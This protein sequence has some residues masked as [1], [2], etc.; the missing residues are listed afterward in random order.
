MPPSGSGNL[1]NDPGFVNYA[2][3]NFQLQSNSP[4]INSGGYSLGYLAAD[5]AGNPRVV[6]GFVDIGAYEYQSAHFILPWL[7]AQTYGL[8]LDGSI[9][10]D[11]DGMNNWQEAY[12]GTNPTNSA[13]LLKIISVTPSTAGA[14]VEWQSVPGHKYFVQHSTSLAAYPAFTTIL[15]NITAFQT[16]SSTID[17]ATTTNSGPYFYRVAVP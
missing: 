13:L 11:G 14:F 6:D 2:S 4:C 7:F 3:G 9:D 15:T 17:P 10:S 16:T 12:C 5:L 8:S 1:T